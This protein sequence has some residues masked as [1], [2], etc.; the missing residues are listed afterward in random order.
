MKTVKP[1]RKP[2]DFEKARKTVHNTP[3]AR[4]S[5]FA[6]E[7]WRRRGSDVDLVRSECRSRLVPPACLT[8]TSCRSKTDQEGA[9]RKIRHSLRLEPRDVSRFALCNRGFSRQA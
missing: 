1:C 3:A 8:V 2:C 9:G 5:E 7:I 6:K 4:R